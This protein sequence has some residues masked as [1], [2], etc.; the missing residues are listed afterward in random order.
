[1][2]CSLTFGFLN[3]CITRT[4]ECHN[5]RSIG[6]LILSTGG[7]QKIKSKL[8]VITDNH[9]ILPDIRNYRTITEIIY[10]RATA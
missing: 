4:K 3:P 10:R 9:E 1:M 8:I 6:N 5:F 2:K 7:A